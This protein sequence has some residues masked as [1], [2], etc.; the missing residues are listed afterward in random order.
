MFRYWKRRASTPTA[1]I[2]S[3][4][5]RCSPSPSSLRCL[6]KSTRPRPASACSRD[7]ARMRRRDGGARQPRTVRRHS[8]L[9]RGAECRGDLRG[10][11]GGGGKP[12]GKP[13]NPPDRPWLDR[14]QTTDKDRKSVV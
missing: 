11:D 12:C 7:A 5:P 2:I 14:R 8:L 13:R 1:N 10:G 3:P 9:Q 6:P 4:P